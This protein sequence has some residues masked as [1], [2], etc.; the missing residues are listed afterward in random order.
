MQFLEIVYPD[1]F[2][3]KCF[4]SL[5]HDESGCDIRICN[6]ILNSHYQIITNILS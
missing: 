4:F 5:G 1:L 2:L 3:V 6:I